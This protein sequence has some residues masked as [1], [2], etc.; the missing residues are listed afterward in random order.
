M[1]KEAN[2][3]TYFL[4]ALLLLGGNLVTATEPPTYYVE[5]RAPDTYADFQ[6]NKNGL[7]ENDYYSEY[8]TYDEPNTHI[9]KQTPKH[10]SLPWRMASGVIKKIGNFCSFFIYIVIGSYI[11]AHLHK[12]SSIKKLY[13]KGEI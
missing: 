3:P 13:Y 10:T 2:S 11:M 6:P 9:Y 4:L 5:E 12:C 1:P 8:L 7:D